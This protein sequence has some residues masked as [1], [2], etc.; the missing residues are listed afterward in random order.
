MTCQTFILAGPA[1]FLWPI[2]NL[3]D[4]P[5]SLVPLLDLDLQVEF[6]LREEPELRSAKY[7]VRGLSAG[8][9]FVAVIPRF[10]MGSW[11]ATWKLGGGRFL[12]THRLWRFR[13]TASNAPA[14][15]GAR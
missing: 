10:R 1:R 7:P 6:W 11:V 15:R 9:Q 14:S 12:T 2:R 8:K 5:A 3:V 4:Q 13:S